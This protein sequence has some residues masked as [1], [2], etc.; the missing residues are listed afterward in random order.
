MIEFAFAI[1][2]L[3]VLVWFKNSIKVAAE[4]LEDTSESYFEDVIV[5]NA[6]DRQERFKELTEYKTRN[7]IDTFVS[8]D[9]I[10]KEVSMKRR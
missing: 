9:D 10:L 5:D 7:S 6:I 1:L 8:H 2:I 3:A 4:A